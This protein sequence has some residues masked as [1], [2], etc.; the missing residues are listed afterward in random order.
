MLQ[1][2]DEIIESLKE[3]IKILKKISP[4]QKMK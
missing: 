2:K 4:D 1:E 3:T